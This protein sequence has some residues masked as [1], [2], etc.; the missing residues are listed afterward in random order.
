MQYFVGFFFFNSGI[1]ESVQFISQQW[2]QGH[3]TLAGST[4]SCNLHDQSLSQQH[5]RKSMGQKWA[6][7]FILSHLQSILPA[8]IPLTFA[9]RNWWRPYLSQ[10]LCE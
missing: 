9:C 8:A 6:I 5:S 7:N 3:L 10:G 1:K 2:E 4:A